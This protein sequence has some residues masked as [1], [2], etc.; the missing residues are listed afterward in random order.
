MHQMIY[1][2]KIGDWIHINK[3]S[4]EFGSQSRSW[5]N[6]KTKTKQKNTQTN[7]RKN[8]T[9]RQKQKQNKNNYTHCDFPGYS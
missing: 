7:K 2:K 1:F 4:I 5:I 8:K 9:K 6:I 3:T